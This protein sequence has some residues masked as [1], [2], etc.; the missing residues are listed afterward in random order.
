MS[1]YVDKFRNFLPPW[2]RMWLQAPE[3]REE[4]RA[5]PTLHLSLLAERRAFAEEDNQAVL[6]KR[7]GQTPDQV[8]WHNRRLEHYSKAVRIFARADA[9]ARSYPDMLPAATEEQESRFAQKF[10]EDAEAMKLIGKAYSGALGPALVAQAALPLALGWKKPGAWAAGFAVALNVYFLGKNHI[11]PVTNS[12]GE[13]VSI[14]KYSP[15]EVANSFQDFV[16][17]EQHLAKEG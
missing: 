3:V 10:P 5:D 13:R 14:H 17:E 15:R 8:A 1:Q 4:D 9:E 16:Y 12:A 7:Y 2:P 11:L 6:A